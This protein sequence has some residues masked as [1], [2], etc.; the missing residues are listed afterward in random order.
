MGPRNL[1]QFN[2]EICAN[3]VWK[4]LANLTWNLG[5]YG[6]KCPVQSGLENRA[7]M[8]LKIQANLA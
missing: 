6:L 7:K 2:L 4:V 8:A 3:L 5:Q 1:S